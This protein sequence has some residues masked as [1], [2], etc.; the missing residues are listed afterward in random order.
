M[1]KKFTGL[2]REISGFGGGYE[3][4]CRA[5]VLAGVAWCEANPD[6][7]PQFTGYK[8]VF[9]LVHEDNDDAKAL[10]KAV[11]AGGGAGVSGAMHQASVNHVLKIR[12]MGW[13]W[14]VS[15]MSK[16]DD[17]EAVQ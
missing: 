1:D 9:G 7:D 13:G 6:A 15:E 14:Y 11:L 8:N 16:P 4:A 5:M 2:M 10:T 17:N 3:S 12:E